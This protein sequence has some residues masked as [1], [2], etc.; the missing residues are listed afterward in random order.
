M[1]TKNSVPSYEKCFVSFV[2]H[3]VISFTRE[4]ARG[5]PRGGRGD[6]ASSRRGT[7]LFVRRDDD[8]DERWWWSC[9]TFFVFDP[10]KER[11]RER[12]RER[13]SI[14]TGTQQSKEEEEEDVKEKEEEE[15]ETCGFCA[16]MKGGSCKRQFVEWEKCVDDAKSKNEDFVQKCFEQTAALRECML[17]DPEYYGEMDAEEEEEKEKDEEK[18]DEKKKKKTEE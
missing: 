3:N 11:E 4:T 2:S 1:E 16:Y 18:P 10:P 14:M 8:D 13:N 17:K 9:L 5:R 7:P 15:E 12:E 6:S